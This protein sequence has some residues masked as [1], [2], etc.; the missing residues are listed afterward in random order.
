V[1]LDPTAFDRAAAQA[2]SYVA[3]GALP[4]ALLAAGDRERVL[5]IR[6]F[7]EGAEEDPSLHDRIFALASI[8]KAVAATAI[9]RLVDQGSLDYRDPVVKHIPELGTAP[10]RERIT[11]GHIF[12]HSTGLP[13]ANWATYGDLA[14]DGVERLEHAFAGEPLYEPGTRM[15]YATLT[16]QLL[17]EIVWRRLGKPMSAFLAESLFEPFGM[18]DTGFRPVDPAR[19]M[20]VVD[21][22]MDTPEKMERYA[23]AE[24]S[25]SGLWSTAA[26]LIRLAQAVLAPGRLFRTETCRLL[27]EP[28]LRLP[29]LG[30]DTRSH[31][32]WGWNK[33]EH[34]AFPQMPAS[35]FYHGGATGTLLWLDPARDI[36][37]VFL[38]NRWI[39]DNAQAFA[40]LACLYE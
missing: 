20:P 31:R 32:T 36:I 37:F 27:T 35:G 9:A 22:P 14:L 29:M 34:E 4:T 30:A 18:V 6:A 24:L 2:R 39:S 7:G 8:T 15:Q 26:D 1:Q 17:N 38:T 3:S 23:Q 5:A 11:V 12:T 40:T 13:Q 10:W 25:G 16:Y 28:Q 21:H 19:A 33:E